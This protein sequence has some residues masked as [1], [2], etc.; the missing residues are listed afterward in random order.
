MK[1]PRSLITLFL[2]ALWA[3]PSFASDRTLSITAPTQATPGTEL[4][5]IV[6]ASTADT[7]GEQVWFFHSEYSVDQGETWVG[8]S[9][10]QDLGGAVTRT[11]QIKVGPDSS[12]VWV[13]VR[14]SFRG[15]PDGDV[16][17]TGDPIKWEKS[18]ANWSSPPAK[19]VKIPVK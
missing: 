17:F 3:L 1:H 2:F 8:I 11:A 14:A 9:Y 7:A 18:W 6:A 16:D 5:V 19:M 12:Q 15:G 4:S 13:R 10:D